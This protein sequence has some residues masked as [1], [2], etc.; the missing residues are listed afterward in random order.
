MSGG[1]K[2]CTCRCSWRPISVC[3]WTR[4][5]GVWKQ[6]RWVS[7]SS[8]APVDDIVVTAAVA[9]LVW[10]TDDWDFV[11]W[12]IFASL[13]P[14]LSGV[15]PAPSNL[16][17]K[18]AGGGGL[19]VTQAST[20]HLQ[21]SGGSPWSYLGGSWVTDWMDWMDAGFT[22]SFTFNTAAWVDSG[23][24]V[25]FGSADVTPLNPALHPASWLALRCRRPHW[26]SDCFPQETVNNT[27]AKSGYKI[28]FMEGICKHN[29]IYSQQTRI[30]R[31]RRWWEEQCLQTWHSCRSTRACAPQSSRGTP[32]RRSSFLYD[33]S[34]SLFSSDSF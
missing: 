33:Q 4:S 3:N 20:Q 7:G 17:R 1:S 25:F 32:R 2:R 15:T 34:F 26:A 6:S 31:E 9:E 23:K 11:K 5:D 12:K 22:G 10:S 8:S 27:R 19:Q 14:L 18:Y 24:V 29:F 28:H 16:I 30:L 21:P 13:Q